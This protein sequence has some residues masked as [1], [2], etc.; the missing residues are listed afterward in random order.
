MVEGSLSMRT[1]LVVAAVIGT[2]GATQVRASDAP[3]RYDPFY[4]L[5]GPALTKVVDAG[6]IS[7]DMSSASDLFVTG[8]Y[9]VSK[10]LEVG[11]RGTFGFLRDGGDA[12]ASTLVG[13]KYAL[14]GKRTA[15]VDLLLPIGGTSDPGVSLGIMERRKMSTVNVDA[16]LQVGLGKGYVAEGAKVN[17]ELESSKVFDKVMTGYVDVIVGTNTNSI[18]DDL[19][20]DV[21]PYVNYR[22]K[23]GLVASAGLRVN[24]Y[25][26]TTRNSDIGLRLVAIKAL[27]K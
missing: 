22:L 1:A 5:P 24:A 6:L 8:K 13:A 15:T 20:I 26:G 12:L 18:G 23:A 17:L 19:S 9:S 2:I 4:T 25:K 3:L 27:G 16:L 7:D 10:Q 14:A 11:A 21:L